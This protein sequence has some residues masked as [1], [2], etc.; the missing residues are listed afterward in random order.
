MRDTDK[1]IAQIFWSRVNEKKDKP[2]YKGWVIKDGKKLLF[3]LFYKDKKM[4]GDFNGNKFA[5]ESMDI[6]KKAYAFKTEKGQTKV[7]YL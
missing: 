7:S 4:H 3:S 2:G 5:Y 1:T 6:K